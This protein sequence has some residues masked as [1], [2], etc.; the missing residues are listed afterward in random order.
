MTNRLEGKWA[1]V[2]GA[3]SGIGRAT[4]VEFAA[5][6]CNLIING[7]RKER[8][9]NLKQ[10]L[11]TEHS[12]VVE[13]GCFDV[14]DREAC[15]DFISQL[16]HPID[17]LVNNAGL[18]RGKDAVY[19]ASFED[20]DEMVDTN[21]KG[22]LNMTR[23]ISPRMK[24]KNRGHI[25]NVG[26]IAGH[27]SYPGGSVYCATKHA[28]KA[29]TEATKKDLHGTNVRVSMVSPGLVET[30]FSNV[31]FHGDDERADNVYANLDP[32][33][34]EDIAEI[35]HFIANRPPHVNIMDSIVLPV[36]QSSSSMVSRDE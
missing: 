23:L 34:G 29:F 26:S 6:S 17:T 36:S 3:T 18:A 9:D 7:R 35:I 10:Q 25:I 31:R 27:E 13:T 4:A 24:E 5:S 28:V 22:V 12:V 20:W 19:D 30:E 15:S 8:L 2:T 21:I 32:L 11:E 33:T 1:L 14:R 16:E